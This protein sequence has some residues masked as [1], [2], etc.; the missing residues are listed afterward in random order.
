M[1]PHRTF[2]NRSILDE[3]PAFFHMC[4]WGPNSDGHQ[5]NS[6]VLY[7]HCEDSLLHKGWMTIPDIRVF[8][9]IQVPKNGWFIM[10]NPMNKWMIWGGKQPPLFLETPI[11][12]LDPILIRFGHSFLKVHR[13]SGSL[14][15]LQR[16]GNE[17]LHKPGGLLGS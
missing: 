3:T 9:K 1:D 15:A 6:R 13:L 14:P 5:P 16:F 2:S 17:L 12:S 4:C 11:R 10:E 7:T 8:P